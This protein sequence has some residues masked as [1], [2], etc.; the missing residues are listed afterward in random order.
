MS[1]EDRKEIN[2]IRDVLDNQL[3]DRHKQPMGRADGLIIELRTGEPPRLAYIEAGAQTLARR[4]HPKLSNWVS[5]LASRFGKDGEPYRIP[6][7]RVHDVGIDIDVGV[8]AEKTPV[9][10]FEQW[11][12]EHVVGRI[13]GGS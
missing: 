6:W 1:Q 12:R 7:S 2:L 13:P 4:L 9:M 10:L 8:D 3:V 5:K 11:L